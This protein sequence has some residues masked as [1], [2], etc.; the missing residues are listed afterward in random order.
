MAHLFMGLGAAAGGAASAVGGYNRENYMWDEQN[1]QNRVFQ[2]QNMLVSQFSLYREDIRDLFAVAYNKMSSYLVV[3]TLMLGFIVTVFWNFGR[4]GGTLDEGEENERRYG[5]H[6][7][8]AL[9]TMHMMSSFA[10]LI[11]SLWFAMQTITISQSFMTKILVETVRIPLPNEQE[12][13][14]AAATA[15]DFELSFQSVFRVPLLSKIRNVTQETLKKSAFTRNQPIEH[16]TSLNTRGVDINELPHIKLYQELMKNWLPF[17]FYCQVCQSIGVSTL[18]SGL[19]YYVLYYQGGV[20]YLFTEESITS[21]AMNTKCH[22]A[23]FGLLAYIFLSLLTFWQTHGS[24]DLP[25]FHYVLLSTFLSGSP[26]IV[27]MLV[28]T[29]KCLNMSLYGIILICNASWVCMLC[30]LALAA[31]PHKLSVY[32]TSARYIEPFGQNEHSQDQ[33][34]LIGEKRNVHEYDSD[35]SDTDVE[36]ACRKQDDDEWLDSLACYGGQRV[37]SLKSY[38]AQFQPHYSVGKEVARERFKGL[39]MMLLLMWVLVISLASLH[40][41]E[42]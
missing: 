38:V 18:L 42:Q 16:R 9:F 27:V 6:E 41:Y 14:G 7:I 35:S 30:Y 19:S 24:L 13:T 15:A 1:K 37:E 29:Q 34:V 26:V 23:P 5:D 33:K 3:S 21:D 32:W 8:E 11:T 20:R 40:E 36:A 25:W 39:S 28:A 17:D 4:T 31:E 12:I 22:A 2:M 10:F